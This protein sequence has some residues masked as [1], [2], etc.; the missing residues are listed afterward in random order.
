MCELR[1]KRESEKRKQGKKEMKMLKRA[2]TS[3]FVILKTTHA[4][5]EYCALIKT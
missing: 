5:V 4:V 1:N 3:G 2:R